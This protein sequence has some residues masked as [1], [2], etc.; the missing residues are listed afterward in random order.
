MKVFLFPG[1]ASQKIGMGKALYDAF[2]EAREVF[3]VVSDSLQQNMAHLIFNGDEKE[4]TLT[5]NAQPAIMTISMAVLAVILKQSGKS[6]SELTNYVAGHSLGE[7]SATCATGCITLP[8]TA[9]ILKIRGKSMQE[10]IAPNEGAMV[11]LIGAD[12]QKAQEI[13]TKAQQYGICQ[14]ANDNSTGQVVLTGNAVAI[15]NIVENAKEYGLRRAIKL[16]V[17]APFHSPYMKLAAERVEEAL[18][19]IG[20]S[21]PKVPLIANYSAEKISEAQQLKPLLVSQITNMVRWREIMLNLQNEHKVTDFI[22][23]GYGGVL[24]GL[25]KKTL[26]GVNV[27]SVCEP[28]EIDAFMKS[29]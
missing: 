10:A 16:N 9:K 29:C 5:E 28:E 22:E 7:Y 18:N 26:E 20:F 15:D 24:A 11:A 27:S 6:I 23:I 21:E 14:V 12:I 13:C 1:Q 3:E 25:V 8:D 4:L 17:S 19:N 2:A